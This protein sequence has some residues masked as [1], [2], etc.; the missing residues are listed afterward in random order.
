MLNWRLN[1]KVGEPDF[2]RPQI[3]KSPVKLGERAHGVVINEEATASTAKGKKLPPK[4]GKEKCKAPIAETL[5]YNSSSKGKSYDSQASFSEPEDDHLLQARRVELCSKV[6]KHLEVWDTLR[7]HRF[8]VFTRPHGPYIPT[9]VLE[10][11][12]TYGDLVPQVKKKASAIKPV[13]SGKRQEG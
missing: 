12:A 11:Y 7:F 9:W 4:G 6:D 13:E 5:E 10:F 8:E 3:A 2:V 1:E